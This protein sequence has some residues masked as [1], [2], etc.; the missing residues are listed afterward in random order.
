[1]RWAAIV[2][3]VSVAACDPGW[4]YK[5]AGATA[6]QA[7]GRRFDLPTAH[8]VALRVYSSVFTVHLQFELDV[9]NEDGQPL[10]VDASALHIQ[11]SKGVALPIYSA[12]GP[13][14]ILGDD[15]G[16]SDTLESGE[17]LR[18]HGDFLVA[19]RSS[20]LKTLTVD[21][22]GIKRGGKAVPIRIT[23]ERG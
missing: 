1:M 13:P 15:G 14:R 12:N 7:D 8:G 22:D 21:Y 2:V 11:D 20:D 9:R 10:S 17:S 23:L 6:V 19:P 3:L 16:T 5:V 18:I 4:H